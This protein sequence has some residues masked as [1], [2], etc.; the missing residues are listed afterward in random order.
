MRLALQ[1]KAGQRQRID[2]NVQ[3]SAARKFGIEKAVLHVKLF[4][5]AKILL[6]QVDWTKLARLHAAN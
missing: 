4:V 2:A 1:K 3:Q 5:A 6:N